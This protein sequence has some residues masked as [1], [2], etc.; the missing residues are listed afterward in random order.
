ML[1]ALVTIVTSGK[2]IL[3]HVTTQP[4]TPLAQRSLT[5]DNFDVT[6]TIYKIITL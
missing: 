5:P 1:F 3:L 2:G 4:G 6:G